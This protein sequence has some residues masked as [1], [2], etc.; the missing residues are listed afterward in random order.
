MS[1]V[2]VLAVV[3]AAIVLCAG[4]TFIFVTRGIRTGRIR[5]APRLSIMRACTS[6][7]D[8]DRRNSR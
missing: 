5:R 4:A 1:D 2:V 8:A 6:V 3:I 7:I